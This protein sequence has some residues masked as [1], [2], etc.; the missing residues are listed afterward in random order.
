MRRKR[1]LKKNVRN[2][3]IIALVLVVGIVLINNLKPSYSKQEEITDFKN[4]KLSE[5]QDYAKRN[6]LE[7]KT[8]YTYDDSIK[9][10]IVIES[11]INDKT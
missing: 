8:E 4:M 9:K 3:L 11:S 1:R 5:V 10:D 7:L 2:V 6:K